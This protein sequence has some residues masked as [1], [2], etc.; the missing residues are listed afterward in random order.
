VLLLAHRHALSLKSAFAVGG[1]QAVVME[2]FAI[3]K[4]D[5]LIAC[6]GTVREAIAKHAPAALANYTG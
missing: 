1:A 5:Q 6:H 3:S 2:I 4:F